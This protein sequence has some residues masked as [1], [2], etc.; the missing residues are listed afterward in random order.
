MRGRLVAAHG[1]ALTVE[2]VMMLLSLRIIHCIVGGVTDVP[3][4]ALLQPIVPKLCSI[5][6]QLTDLFH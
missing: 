6:V 5:A 1:E 3:I 4:L 2:V